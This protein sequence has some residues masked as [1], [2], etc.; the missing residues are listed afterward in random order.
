MKEGGRGSALEGGG[1]RL[2]VYTPGGLRTFSLYEENEP[3]P[4]GASEGL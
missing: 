2:P 1:C 4:R 3:E